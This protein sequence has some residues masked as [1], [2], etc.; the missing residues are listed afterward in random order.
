MVDMTRAEL[1]ARFGIMFIRE[2]DDLDDVDLAA[3]RT[4]R[5]VH[6]LLGWYLNAPKKGIMVFMRHGSDDPRG[7]LDDVLTSLRVVDNDIIWRD[8]FANHQVR[9]A[10]GGWRGLFRRLKRLLRAGSAH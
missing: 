5:G 6:A 7:E 1:S 10:S 9:P 3:I 2:R 4:R 8:P